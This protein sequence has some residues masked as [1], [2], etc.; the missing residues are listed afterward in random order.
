MISNKS[1]LEETLSRFDRFIPEDKRFI[2]TVK[3]QEK[4]CKDKSRG[5]IN[6]NGLIF[7]P[8]GRNT[9]PCILMSLA[10][11]IQKGVDYDANYVQKV[12]MSDNA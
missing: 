9:A 11:L 4:L 8:T 1:L 2:V 10:S 3:E 5:Q 7:E 12:N 6:K